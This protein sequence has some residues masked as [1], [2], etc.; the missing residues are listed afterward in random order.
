MFG[1]SNPL[2]VNE[3]SFT[4]AEAPLLLVMIAAVIASLAAQSG[5]QPFTADIHF[6]LSGDAAEVAIRANKF[7]GSQLHNEVDFQRLH[8]PHV[9]LYLTEWQC[10]IEPE[11]VCK[12]P[13]ID[14]L[15]GA[16]YAI[17]A[18]ICTVT[19]GQ[20]FASGNF[21]MLNVSLSPCLQQASDTV[22][23]GTYQLA[24]ANQSVPSWVDH[25]PEPVRS[26]KIAM[27]RKY[28][29]PNV[30]VEGGCR[31]PRYVQARRHG[32]HLT[33]PFGFF[34]ALPPDRF[35]ANSSRT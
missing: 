8:T 6:P 14:A 2:A 27:I 29:S 16:L 23:K 28:G 35:S 21:A 20:P 13:L 22:V 17:S 4:L 7:L 9:T 11:E 31:T 33:Q 19:L 12:D 32:S 3:A 34:L 24:V 15:S 25:L 5:G 18:S 26:E 30:S 1:W 10:E